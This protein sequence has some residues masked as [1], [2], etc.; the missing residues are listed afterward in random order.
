MTELIPDGT[1]HFTLNVP[2]LPSNGIKDMH[3]FTWNGDLDSPILVSKGGY[4]EPVI[5]EFAMPREV[6][7]PL[8]QIAIDQKATQMMAAMMMVAFET[9]CIRWL[10]ANGGD[11][12]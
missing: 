6:Y 12:Q 4:A 8:A 2:S 7:D 10:R 9:A 5:G 1:G 3:S 11:S